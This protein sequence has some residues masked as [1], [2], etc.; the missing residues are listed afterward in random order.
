MKIAVD[1]MGGDNAPREI[2]KGALAASREIN[3]DIIL[4]GDREQLEQFGPLPKNV[5]IVH[6][7]EIISNEEKPTIALRKKKEASIS[8]ATRLVR[9]GEADAV[10]SAGS[11]GAQMAAALLMLGRLPN[12]HR[13]AIV[14]ILP[15]ITSPKVLLDAGANTD[16]KPENLLEFAVMGSIY[17]RTV[18][19][20]KDPLVGLLNI[21]SEAGKGNSLTLEAYEL[22][23]NADIN[24]YGNIEAREIPGSEVSIIV[25]DGFV[26]NALLKFGE[27]LASLFYGL[28]KDAVGQSM[29][30]KLGGA[31]LLPALKD[32]QKK[33]DWEEY[34]GAPLLGVSKV[35]IVCHG[36]SKAN[37]IKSAVKVAEKCVANDF[38]KH[39][40]QSINGEKV[41]VCQLERDL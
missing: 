25:C 18:M 39:I 17:A 28:L 3:G 15:G 4:V 7:T 23:K 30:T 14:A 24:F 10:V 19:G 11:T 35:S 6:S 13:P 40:S 26:G 1:A 31:C 32:I 16:C 9:D 2:V 33:L 38:I 20:I 22:L 37:A 36:S 21:G 12:I 8:V 34:G 5:S 41:N 29:V 27:G